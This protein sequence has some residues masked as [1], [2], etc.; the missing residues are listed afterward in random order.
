M[1]REERNSAWPPSWEVPTSKETLAR[2]L[3]LAKIIASVFPA[4]GDSRY[5]PCFIRPARS[6]RRPSSAWGKSLRARKSCLAMDSLRVGQNDR[7]R[8]ILP[9]PR[10]DDKAAR[11]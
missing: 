5:P 3:D 4:S 8:G 1:S 7:L 11:E 9:A 2:V 6:R 10:G